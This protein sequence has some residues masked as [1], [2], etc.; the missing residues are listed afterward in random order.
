MESRG[1][2]EIF[3]G[4]SLKHIL[5]IGNI[6]GSDSLQILAEEYISKKKKFILDYNA[7][8]NTSLAL[9]KSQDERNLVH[10]A[11]SDQLAWLSELEKRAEKGTSSAL[12]YK[13]REI[14]ELRTIASRIVR[15]QAEPGKILARKAKV[16]YTIRNPLRNDTIQEMTRTF[17]FSADNKKVLN[18]IR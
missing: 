15:Y 6:S 3:N 5:S 2:V 18:V 17:I 16:I 7:L 11:A 12:V 8:I 1:Q 9:K 14:M 13:Q 10:K 4:F